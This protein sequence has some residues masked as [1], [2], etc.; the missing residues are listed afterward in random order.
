MAL[1]EPLD[2]TALDTWPKLLEHN[3]RTLGVRHRAMRYKHYGIWQSYTWR[4]YLDQVRYVAL[5][6]LSL[7]FAPGNK[8]LIVGDNCA[9]WYF[10]LLAA[11]CDRGLGVGLYSE[12]SAPEI[13]FVASNSEAEFAMVEDQEQVDKMIQI[14]DRLPS[15]KK[16]VYWRYKG[17]GDTNDDRLIGLREVVEAGRRYEAEHP[18]AFEQNVAAGK[19]DDLCAIVYTSGTTGKPRG[20][21]HSY[22]SLM[23]G[24]QSFWRTDHLNGKDEFASYLP[25]A[26]IN[27]QWLAFGCHL[28][29]GGIVSFAENS[30]TQQDDV[31]E[32]A[33]TLVV[34]NS[35][36]WENLAGQVR[37]KLR[38]ASWLKRLASNLFMPVALKV[39]DLQEQ[40]R[41][42]SPQLRLL[43]VLGALLIF[44]RVRDSVGLV[45]ARVCYSTG[46]MLSPQ[47]LRF[48][49]AIGVPLKN[50]YG[51]TEAG[52]VT[53]VTGRVQTRGTVGTLNEG[54]E[55][56]Q[57]D[58]GELL[59]RHPGT[60]VGYYN[61]PEATA[62]VLREGWVCTGDQCVLDGE[63]LV[64]VDRLEDLI[65]MPCG[66]IV[67]PQEIESRLKYSPYI[68]DA[69]VFAGPDCDSLSAVIIIDE[70]TTGHW[71][72][73][74]KVTF[75]TFGDL[76]QKTEVYELV[77]QEIALVNRDLP[78]TQHIAKYVNLHK[79]FDP[80]ES[81]LTRNRK[82]RRGVL[83][84]E[85]S[86][87]VEAMAGDG[88]SIEVE[89]EITYQDGRTG[90]LK[91]AVR[92]GTIGSLAKA[93]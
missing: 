81:E 31:R 42:P 50:V 2:M 43:N 69:W 61:D 9:E 70:A 85:Y 59:V 84:K 3:S 30:E 90:R 20:A 34:Y 71:A 28:L 45:H 35:R 44:R 91:T 79:E 86:N 22:Q 73:K 51:S 60:F 62:R 4:D 47:T 32:I 24:A 53:R 75:T 68:K 54:V 6:L 55:A 49:H 5:G 48:F 93:G 37:A 89:A 16:I 23:A 18:G 46:S 76:S 14:I 78:E 58:D 15:L 21:L 13:E 17:L 39:A 67:S 74:H 92:I 7:G 25:P 19:A 64:F 38:A 27:E 72:D 63:N 33:P 11:Q 87:L 1:T 29:S 41:K 82:L 40:G 36:L 88:S 77:E 80:D 83:A 66:E 56:R 12:L 8:L 10:A 65:A 52:S 57:N 26:W